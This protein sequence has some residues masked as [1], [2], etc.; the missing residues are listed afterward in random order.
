MIS[1]LLKILKQKK[2]ETKLKNN[3]WQFIS[4]LLKEHPNC[5]SQEKAKEYEKKWLITKQSVGGPL[6]D[7]YPWV[8]FNAM[9]YMETLLNKESK[10]FEFG[11]GG[12][13]V[14]F[15]KRV[16]E[17]ISVEHDSEWFL[18]TKNVMSDVKDLKWT[19]YLKQ[20]RVT[21]IP[22]T[23]DGADPSLYTTTD[24]SMSGQSF[25]DYVTTIDQYEDKYFDLILIDGR[26]RPSCFMHALPK[27]KDGGYIVLD[28]AE[29]EAY[30]IVEEVSKSSGFKIEEYWGPGPYNDHGWRTIFIK[31]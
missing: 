14:F 15:S 24:E 30:R 5:V 1:A 7:G 27:I 12:S 6:Q 9:E 31:K 23:G 21:E 28:N 10:V 22:I 18:R 19:G 13:T 2:Q 25:K 11:I 8:P 17:L 29:R 16:G 26:S 20:P 4:E 3:Y